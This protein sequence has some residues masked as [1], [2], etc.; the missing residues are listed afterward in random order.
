MQMMC[1]KAFNYVMSVQCIRHRDVRDADIS[2]NLIVLSLFKEGFQ[3]NK[4]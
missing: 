1:C 2:G 3:S 4:V